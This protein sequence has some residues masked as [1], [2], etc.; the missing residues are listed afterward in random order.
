MQEIYSVKQLPDFERPR[1]RLRNVGPDA[2]STVELIAVILGSGTKESPVLQLAQEIVARFDTLDRLSEATV[3]EFCQV[4]GIGT[5]K[6]VQ[7]RAAL[8]LGMRVSRKTPSLKQK[9]STPMQAYLFIKDT[10][11]R[12]KREIFITLLLDVKGCAI[13][14]DIVSIGTLSRTLVH[15]REVFYPAVRHK[16]ASMILAHNHPSGDPTPSS[17]DFEVTNTL[18]EIGKLMSIPVNDHLIIGEKCFVSLRQKG[19]AFE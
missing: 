12:E 6:A 5:I 11:E 3:E 2:L 19:V 14:H 7:L 13:R 1:E 15:P 9:I 18:V 4:K 16:A 17:E 10:L 8:S